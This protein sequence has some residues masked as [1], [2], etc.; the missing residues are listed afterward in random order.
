MAITDISNTK[1]LLNSVLGNVPY[2]VIT[3]D[4]KGR[5]TIINEAAT[6]I[7]S[8]HEKIDAYLDE[9]ILHFFEAPQKTF[10]MIEECIHT[11][12]IEFDLDREKYKDKFIKITGRKLVDGMLF[13]IE[14]ITEKEQMI[15]QIEERSAQLEVTNKELEQFAYITSHDLQ[16]PLINIES[17][18]R[19]LKEPKRQ[20]LLSE[21]AQQFLKII[22]ESAKKMSQQIFGL[23]QYSR[24]GN[25]KEKKT[26]EIKTLINDV[27]QSLS[28]QIDSNHV[29]I[30]IGDLPDTLFLFKEEIFSLFQ[31]LIT[32]AIK[33]RKAEVKPRIKISSETHKNLIKFSISDN[34][35]GFPENKKETI[36]EI[37]KRLNNNAAI[38]GN[39]IGLAHCKKIIELHGGNIWADSILNE[40]STFHFTISQ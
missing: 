17:F 35:I 22:D 34:G 1:Y 18:I 40:G 24:L 15:L 3:T 30:E 36:F 37:F 7:L 25:N 16:E 33:Y 12:R 23:L 2:G 10:E 6:T 9:N 29:V 26:V 11:S 13:T 20:E 14:D 38:E 28:N 32:N 39:G 21:E 5:I 19:L 31:N 8:Q 27:I 4:F